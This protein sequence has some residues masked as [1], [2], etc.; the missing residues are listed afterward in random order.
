MGTYL[1]YNLHFRLNFSFSRCNSN[2]Y[3]YSWMIFLFAHVVI[4]IWLH[5]ASLWLHVAIALLRCITLQSH[6]FNSSWQKAKIAYPTCMFVIIATLVSV[7]PTIIVHKISNVKES[8]MPDEGDICVVEYATPNYSE[9]MYTLDFSA[10]AK[11]DNCS[12]FKAN[13]WLTGIV[14]KVIPCV[15]LFLFLFSLIAKLKS[16]KARR[17]K[18][19]ETCH[20]FSTE[21]GAKK[22]YTDRTT[23]ML[24]AIMIVFLLTELPQSFIFIL[25]AIY[26]NDVFD[27][28]YRNLADFIDLLSLI[29]SSFNFIMYCVMSS[30]Y[31]FV[32]GQVMFNKRLQNWFFSSNVVKTSFFTKD[33]FTT[34]RGDETCLK[35]TKTSLTNKE[36]VDMKRISTKQIK[37][38]EI[39]RKKET[40][41]EYRDHTY[42]TITTCKTKFG[43]NDMTDELSNSISM[44]SSFNELKDDAQSQDSK[45]SIKSDNIL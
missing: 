16:T 44:D 34:N 28:V 12:V 24:L 17:K 41:S 26:T 38:K 9:P 21:N 33:L 6:S 37:A 40:V 15:L 32:F 27:K 3:S 29:N 23:T 18:L 43:G 45:Q 35:M 14:N 25:S 39:P 30:R 13:L 5:S 7:I 20:K 4:S 8:W 2:P 11:Q 36:G 31:R 19:L 10:Y 22:K 1:I 42:L